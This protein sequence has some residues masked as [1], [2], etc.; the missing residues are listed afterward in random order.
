MWIYAGDNGVCSIQM[1]T[2]CLP[3]SSACLLVVHICAFV[4][5]TACFFHTRN[6]ASAQGARGGQRD[7]RVPTGKI[8]CEGYKEKYVLYMSVIKIIC[9]HNE[10]LKPCI[11]NIVKNI[12][13]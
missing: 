5:K 8:S 10:E 12:V 2:I 13:F 7:G 11:I 3:P 6:S 4:I 9:V 1:I